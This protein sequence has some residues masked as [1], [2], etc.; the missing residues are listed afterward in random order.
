MLFIFS[1]LDLFSYISCPVFFI[2]LFH[3][4]ITFFFNSV[5]YLI[6]P[7]CRIFLSG[8]FCRSLY[9]ASLPGVYKF[10]LLFIPYFLI[11]SSS[12]VS[13]FNKLIIT[14]SHVY[15]FHSVHPIFLF[16]PVWILLPIPISVFPSSFSVVNKSSWFFP[17]LFHFQLFPR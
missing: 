8:L 5:V 15:N 2:I 4:I 1:P 3:R 14:L 10:L 9:R 6:I 17:F 13:V 7:H 11:T 16:F 12:G